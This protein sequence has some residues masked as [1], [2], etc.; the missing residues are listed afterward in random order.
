MKEGW[1][2]MTRNTHTAAMPHRKR[3][4]WVKHSWGVFFQA[5]TLEILWFDK[6]VHL[7]VKVNDTHAHTH[8]KYSRQ[9]QTHTQTW[10]NTNK[11]RK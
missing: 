1:T 9:E 7:L 2:D 4:F 5:N 6:K 11:R 10:R 3:S 8:A